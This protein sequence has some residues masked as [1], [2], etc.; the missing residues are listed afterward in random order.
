M[1]K[2]ASMQDVFKK[3]AKKF[4]TPLYL[5][6]ENII[7]SKINEVFKTFK[8]IDFHPTFALKANSNPNLLKIMRDKGFGSDVVSS[9]ELRASIM[10]GV[11]LKSIVWNGCGKSRA[12]MAEFL[13]AG[14]GKVNIDSIEEIALW[15]EALKSSKH[16]PEFFVR[17]NSEVD[18]LTHPFIAT[19]LKKHKFGIPVKLLVNFFETAKKAG[20]KISGFHSHIG[21]QVTDVTPYFDAFS[22][23]TAMAEEYGIKKINIGG[24]WGIDYTGDKLNLAEYRKKVV[25]LFKNF[26]ITAEFGR[27]IVAEAGFYL[28]TVQITKYNGY[29][30]FIVANGGMN[31]LLR[32]ALYSAIHD[33]EVIGK[34]NNKFEASYNI[35]GPLCESGDVLYT[36]RDG[37]LP[38]PGSVIVFKN[39]GAYGYAMASNYN[40]TVRPAEVL[41]TS[42]GELKLIR[43]RETLDDLFAGVIM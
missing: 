31:H 29:K 11:D 28:V 34:M 14:I 35:V 20:I 5:Y 40:G 24:G 27:F 12:E 9:G 22:Q 23:I 25:P 38:E 32:P 2:E 3:A 43:K 17:I 13:S 37:G 33:F 16:R 21:S 36:N 15:R 8:G 19:G 4:D 30:Y 39:T 41:I 10:A 6:S 1:K 7:L 18:A 42:G 26:E